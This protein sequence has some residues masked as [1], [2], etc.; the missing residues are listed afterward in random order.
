MSGTVCPEDEKPAA[1]LR[2]QS[3]P[4]AA[5]RVPEF[6]LPAERVGVSLPFASR[7]YAGNKPKQITHS[8]C[9]HSLEHFS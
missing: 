5:I 6:L 2:S 4:V 3:Q 1:H 7:L 8:C 9:S